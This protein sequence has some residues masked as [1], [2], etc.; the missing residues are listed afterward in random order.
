VKIIKPQDGIDLAHTSFYNEIQTF[1]LKKKKKKKKGGGIQATD[2]W[3]YYG[4]FLF[5]KETDEI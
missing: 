1:I 2:F 4:I 5:L 3:H